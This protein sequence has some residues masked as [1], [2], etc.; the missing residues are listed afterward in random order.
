MKLKRTIATIGI[1]GIMLGGSLVASAQ[2]PTASTASL[3]ALIEQL[4]AQ[5]S[6]LKAQMEAAAK[7]K[8]QVQQTAGEVKDTLKLIAQLR[9]GMTSEDVKLLQ[10][11]LAADPAIYPEGRVT[12]YYGKLTAQA[13]KRFQK[14]HGLDQVGNVGPKTLEKINEALRKNPVAKEKNNGEEHCAIVPPGHLIAPGWLRKQGGVKPIVPACQTLPPGIAKKLGQASTT[15]P[16]ST[17]DVV[18][19]V[20][21]Q[22]SSTGITYAAAHITWTTNE[23]ANSKVWYG[24]TSPVGTSSPSAS[25]GALVVNHD[26]ML[27]GLTANTTYYYVVESVDAAGNKA[28]AAQQSFVTLAQPDTT[29]PVVSQLAVASI[30]YSGA[31]VTWTTN[32]SANSK[33]WYTPTSPVVT[34]GAPTMSSTALVTSHDLAL[35]GLAASTTYYYVVGSADASG[36]TV[37]ATEGSFV[38]LPAPDTTGPV[39][40]GVMATSTATSSSRIVWTTNE[41]STSKIWYGTVSPIVTDGAPSMSVTDLVLSHDLPLSGLNASTTYHYVVASVDSAGNTT[42]FT[43]QSFI[44]AAQ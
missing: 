17:P 39:L 34:T 32:E 8:A 18:A 21:S 11:V 16:T 37:I 26:L 7:A 13:V 15:P 35:T 36:N 23:S 12:G 2:T 4:Q 43:E 9:E 33:I 20:I 14:S 25:A 22:V 38:T 3:Q 31:H 5:I 1:L 30:T 42:K 40:S 28:T 10:V 41:L 24:T 27:T 19:P 44:T 6:T 29:A